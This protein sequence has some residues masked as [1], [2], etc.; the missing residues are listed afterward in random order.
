MMENA[1][2]QI[3]VLS[4]GQ[5]TPSDFFTADDIS[6]YRKDNGWKKDRTIAV[7]HAD[8]ESITQTRRD[9]QQLAEQILPCTIIAAREI[10]GIPYAVFDAAGFRIFTIAELSDDV[11]N[12]IIEDVAQAE[13]TAKLQAQARHQMRPI[14][15]SP[16][17]YYFLDLIMLQTENPEI[18]TKMALADFLENTP[19]MMLTLRCNHIPPW[20]QKTGSYTIETKQADSATIAYIQNKICRE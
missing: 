20:I 6:I 3:A 4:G 7:T 19:F 11:L 2:N 13:Q 12:S 9:V 14:K 10:S 1:Y 16:A 8:T 18:S 5:S 17:G 15:T